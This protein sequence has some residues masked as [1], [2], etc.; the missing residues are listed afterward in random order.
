MIQFFFL[1]GMVFLMWELLTIFEIKKVHNFVMTFKAVS[2]VPLE[3]RPSAHIFYS[4]L[5]VAYT[6]WCMIGLLTSQWPLCLILVLASFIQ[7]NNI[8]ARWIDAFISALIL[9]FM[10]INANY[11]QIDVWKWIVGLF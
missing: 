1:F 6:F 4:L 2:G 5:M 9:S 3:M 8:I 7:R 10:F 11:F